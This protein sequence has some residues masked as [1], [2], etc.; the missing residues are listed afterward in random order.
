MT[1]ANGKWCG[2]ISKGNAVI[3]L[4]DHQPNYTVATCPSEEHAERAVKE[5]RAWCKALVQD[6]EFRSLCRS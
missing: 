3:L 2:L 6:E 5:L 4:G 1:K